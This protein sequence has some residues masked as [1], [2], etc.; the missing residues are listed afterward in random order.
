M[1]A[2]T[3]IALPLGANSLLFRAGAV[4]QEGLPHLVTE[5]STDQPLFR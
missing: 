1:D 5:R 3:Y 2:I 4:L